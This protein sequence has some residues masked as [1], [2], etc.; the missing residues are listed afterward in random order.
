MNA[1]VP[2]Q[3]T[4]V[5]RKPGIDP[6]KLRLA[7]L[8]LVIIAMFVGLFSRLW[9][10]QVLASTEYDTL[11]AENRV[12]EIYTEPPRGRI[13][14]RNHNV[15][16][17]NRRTLAVLVNRQDLEERRLDAQV[18]DGCPGC[19]GVVDRLAKLLDI[20]AGRIRH[21]LRDTTVSPY[22]P[23]PVA[24]DVTEDKAEEIEVNQE[25]FP[26]VSVDEI[27]IRTYPKGALAP[28]IL[29]YVNEISPEQLASP[30]FKNARV[31]PPYGPGDIVGRDGVEYTYD[32]FLRGKP[33]VDRV[34]VNS[35]GKIIESEHVQDEQAGNDL[36]LS[37]DNRIQRLAENAL[38]YG[39]NL[40]KSEGY[41][42]P[43]GAVVVLDPKDGGVV[44]MASYPTYDASIAAD[45]FSNKEFRQLGARTKDDPDDVALINRAIQAQR[46]PASTMKVVTAGA[47]MALNV[48]TSSSYVPC[49]ASKAYPPGEPGAEVFDDIVPVDRGS[50]GFSQA[51]TV[52]CDTFFYEL[53]WQMETIF[54]EEEQFQKYARLA[55]L[56][57]ETGLD[58]PN[59]ADGRIP[60]RKW[61]KEVYE[62]TK[63]DK[64][65]V[66]ARGWLPGYSVNMAIGQGDVIATPLQMAVTT[67]ALANGGEVLRPHV[68]DR[69]SRFSAGDPEK[70]VRDI[71]KK[72]VAELPLQED[73]FAVIREGMIGTTGNGAGTAREA[74]S[75][76]PIEIA[77]KTGTAE[78]GDTDLSDAWFISYGPAR[79]EP[80]YVVAVLLQESG[81][82]GETAAPVARYVWDGIVSN[83]YWDSAP[84]SEPG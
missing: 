57:Q 48:V 10:L 15:L 74:F 19:K 26:G 40:G 8:G 83:N 24:Y 49:P 81:F 77:G 44:A 34:V 58:L 61:C 62:A 72:V 51:L 37:L 28:H 82:G 36:I 7:I 38:E 43:A 56:G 21:R 4:S 79:A 18:G 13:L 54:D 80:E 78:L 65:P 41:G 11:A 23:I 16:V 46:S 71:D 73:E 5:A 20:P 60:D 3:P 68:V 27:P 12:R 2:P 64:N 6:V 31:I 25:D 66:C 32:R 75:G 42:S 63:K 1:N 14:D 84:V 35:S 67:A 55:G 47:A 33:G 52:S 76:F 29:G 22:K 9:F 50:M 39:L 70:V 30:E 45:G 69:V 17:D 59:E 53:G